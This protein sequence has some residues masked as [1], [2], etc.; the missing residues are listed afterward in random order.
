MDL[1]NLLEEQDNIVLDTG[2]HISYK[3]S[4]IISVSDEI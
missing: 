1:E 4:L 3:M 2:M